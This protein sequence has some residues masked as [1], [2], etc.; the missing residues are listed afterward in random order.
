M[1]L[2]L[3]ALICLL[4]NPVFAQS[5]ADLS[6]CSY[7]HGLPEQAIAEGIMPLTL[8][9]L[10]NQVVHYRDAAGELTGAYAVRRSLRIFFYDKQNVLMGT[11]VRR[12]QVKTSYFDP[13]GNFLGQCTNHK[14]ILPD[15]R[16]VRFD[17]QRR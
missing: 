8:P 10:D 11:A 5:T 4:A 2:L 12:S 7:S 13:V 9:Y 1:K 15:D 6:G 3:V 17:P 14:L 16:P